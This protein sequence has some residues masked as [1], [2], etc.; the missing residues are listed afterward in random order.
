MAR[1]PSCDL[2]CDSK[3]FRKKVDKTAVAHSKVRWA[4]KERITLAVLLGVTALTYAIGLTIGSRWLL[5]V[6]NAAPAYG[7][8]VNRLRAGERGAA[9]RAML[10]WAV[11]LAVCG[12]LAFACWPH[13]PG[14]T[15]LHGPEYRDEMFHW[16]RTGEGTEGTPRL[17]LPQHV[18][19]LAAFVALCLLSASA[20]SILMGAVLMNYMAYY[21]ASLARAGAPAGIVALLGWQPWAIVRVAAFC[22]LGAVLAEPLLARL[23]RWPYPGW[24]AAR[25]YLAAAA[26]GILADWILKA[27]LAPTWGLW[28]R[29]VLP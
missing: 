16:I 9:V 13:D 3:F 27:A 6:L 2:G 19:H 22:I 14:G 23:G 21:V 24:A 15:I 26:A 25:P 1:R 12:T 10:A 17:F 11:A 8:M 5:P 29:H 4:A 7:L 20:V 28:L 18:L